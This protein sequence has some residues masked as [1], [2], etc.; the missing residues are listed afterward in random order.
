M[1]AVAILASFAVTRARASV[2]TSTIVI[3]SRAGGD[4]KQAAFE[5]Q[6]RSALS[7]YETV[8]LLPPPPL[9]LEAVQLAID[10]EDESV[11]CL[12][13]VAE[14]LKAQAL[15]VVAFEGKGDAGSL[16]LLYFDRKGGQEPRSV[17]RK[18]S[19]KELE[20]E[21]RNAIPDLLGELLAVEEEPAAE[22]AVENKAEPAA[23]P[24]ATQAEPGASQ[25]LPLG[26]IL[27]GGGGVAVLA[28]GVVV[29]L[30][31]KSTEDTYAGRTIDTQ[32]QAEQ[33]DRD[34]KLG[35]QQALV[36]SVLL[37]TGFATLVAAG[38]WFGVDTMAEGGERKPEGTAL[39]PVVGP[40]SAGVSLQGTW[41]GP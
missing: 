15:V 8:E 24:E 14:R 37:G 13:E 10:C 17:A 1:T 9:D 28:A 32:A 26:P 40:R 35:K 7:R 36:A 30:A 27:L 2:P 41:E 20:S 16:R 25:K 22:E 18:A 21:L 39:L 4:A 3:A 5:R 34:R 33:A 6:V 31:A 12:T 11:S 38:I 29:G 23:P 19:G